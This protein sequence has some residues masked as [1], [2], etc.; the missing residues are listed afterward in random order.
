VNR[1]WDELD[2]PSTIAAGQSRRVIT[3]SNSV[4]AELLADSTNEWWDVRA[5]PRRES[6]DDV[7]AASLVAALDSAR[8]RYGDPKK[9][10]WTWSR[11]R[12]ANIWHPLR[13]SSLSALDLPVQGGRSTLSPSSGSGGFG[14]S[15]RMVVEASSS[16]LKAWGT[17]PGG[18]SGNPASSRYKNHL[19]AWLAGDLEPLV[20]PRWIP[21][22]SQKSMSSRLTLRPRE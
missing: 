15:W 20:M 7:L 10:G 13:L 9:K 11:V 18:Q 14:A 3:P 19:G 6:R 16:E 8:H 5:T 4:L 17:Y 22:L 2:A 12:H 1:T 21:E